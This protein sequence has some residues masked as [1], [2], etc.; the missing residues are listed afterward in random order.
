MRG[1]P[2]HRESGTARRPGAVLGRP[3]SQRPSAG[4]SPANRADQVIRRVA[5]IRKPRFKGTCDFRVLQ[6]MLPVWLVGSDS[7]HIRL[8]AGLLPER[9][10]RGDLDMS[11][12]ES[13]AWGVYSHRP[14]GL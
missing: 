13:E 10:L 6:V 5:R 12:A 7:L 9:S 4:R 14:S 2:R 1:R 11:W 3:A 8:M